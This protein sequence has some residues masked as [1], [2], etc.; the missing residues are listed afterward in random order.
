MPLS[1]LIE[2]ASANDVTEIALTRTFT[3]GVTVDPLLS[4]ESF[5]PVFGLPGVV[6]L[7]GLAGLVDRIYL[8]TLAVPVIFDFKFVTASS[9]RPSPLIT[10]GIRVLIDLITAGLF[11]LTNKLVALSLTS[12]DPNDPLTSITTS[13]ANI[14]RLLILPKNTIWLLVAFSKMEAFLIDEFLSK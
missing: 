13:F 9:S 2:V 3:G 10:N 4:F 12:I 8:S 14:I 11:R 1:I 6:G 5:D 7:T